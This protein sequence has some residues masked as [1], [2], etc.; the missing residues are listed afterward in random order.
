[1]RGWTVWSM[2][3]IPRRY[4][5]SGS[6][7]LILE[8]PV[9]RPQKVILGVDGRVSM[10]EHTIDLSIASHETLDHHDARNAKSFVLKALA[11]FEEQGWCQLGPPT[12]I[13]RGGLKPSLIKNDLHAFWAEKAACSLG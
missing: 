3:V 13:E 6:W 8:H 11:S 5:D 7:L 10:C 2:F 12:P 1:M 4:P 9:E